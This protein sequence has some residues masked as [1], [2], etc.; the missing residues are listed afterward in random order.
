MEKLFNMQEVVA[1]QLRTK[2]QTP[3]VQRANHQNPVTSLTFLQSLLQKL[4]SQVIT[5][6]GQ[7]EKRMKMTKT[8]IKQMEKKTKSF[9]MMEK[10]PHK[11]N[12]SLV[13]VLKI[14]NQLNQMMNNSLPKDLCSQTEMTD[15]LH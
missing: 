3:E 5:I 12:L 1:R 10:Q 6:L 7:V 9:W 2:L 13:Q 11:L 15:P 8:K 4:R 14:P